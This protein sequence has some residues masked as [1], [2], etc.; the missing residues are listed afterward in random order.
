MRNSPSETTIG[1]YFSFSAFSVTTS[2]FLKNRFNV[3]S[4]SITAQTISP[5]SA[6]ALLLH[7]YPVAVQMPAPIMLSP[8]TSSAKRFPLPMSSGMVTYPSKFSSLKSGFPAAILPKTGTS[9]VAVSPLSPK[10]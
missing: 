4:P 6:L 1:G 10:H 9:R 5:F 2:S 8:L 3:A 7:D